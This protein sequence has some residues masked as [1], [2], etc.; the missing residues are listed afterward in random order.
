VGEFLDAHEV[1]V[2]VSAKKSSESIVKTLCH[3][4]LS[5]TAKPTHT[6]FW[7]PKAISLPTARRKMLGEPA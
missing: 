6:W 5:G 4:G 1:E 7:M 2:Q 3:T